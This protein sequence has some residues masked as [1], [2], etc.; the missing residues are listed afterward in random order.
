MKRADDGAGGAEVPRERAG[1]SSRRVRPRWPE[2]LA[3]AHALARALQ[4]E[5]AKVADGTA[6][7]HQPAWAEGSA[8]AAAVAQLL[9]R[10]APS[11]PAKPGP[12]LENLQRFGQLL[13]DR[14]NAAGLS[15]AE[16]GR[17]AKLSDA[18]VKFIETA[19]HPASRATLIRLIGVAELGLS[20]EDTAL[21]HPEEFAPAPAPQAQPS[22][23]PASEGGAL[24]CYLSPALNPVA[25]VGELGRF[26]R[27]AGG[28]VEQTAAY[29]DAQSAADYLTVCQQSP[30]VVALRAALPLG[31]M[32]ERIAEGVSSG[33]RLDVVALGAGDGQLEVRLAQALSA[34]RPQ[35]P[36]D[37]CLVDVSQ[38]LLTHA[39][40]QA[41]EAFAAQPEVRVWGLQANFHHLPLHTELYAP[42]SRTYRRLFVMLGGTLGSLDNEPRF[43]RHSLLGARPDDLL[44]L[45][46]QCAAAPADQP[47]EI[48]RRDKSWLAG[49]SAAHQTWLAGPLWR[50]D[51]GVRAVRF[52]WE[53]ETDGAVPHSYALSAVATVQ[54]QGRADRRFSMLR[55]RRYEPD[56]LAR[57]LAACGWQRIA[58]LGYGPPGQRA[59]LLL[60]RRSDAQS[61]ASI[62]LQSITAA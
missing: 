58:Q 61:A 13:R 54:A 20:W 44:L 2:P 32:A 15:R 8:H 30:V 47:E 33:G 38:P 19:K 23:P 53:L 49:V 60:C 42:P 14:R 22:S 36:L 43:L 57:T 31:E 26:L 41:A 37:L 5:L 52:S 55:F 50:H 51:R 7:E 16:L 40:R 18:T 34:A 4:A 28:H 46:F 35:R 62:P 1:R 11:A 10:H 21:L 59:A 25:M 9:E 6:A 3:R 39:L 45:D 48:K 29:L 12:A 17:R 27:G 56:A 24:A